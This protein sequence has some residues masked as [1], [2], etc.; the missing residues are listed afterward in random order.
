M[1][2]TE[3]RVKLTGDP[4][5]KLKAFCS[6]TF[7][8]AFVVRDLKIIEGVKG[9]FIAMPSRKLSDRCGRCSNK[10]HLR[11]QYCN[12]CGSELDP[13]RAQRDVRGRA[14]LHADLAHPINS[15]CRITLH[16]SVVAAYHEEVEL[17]KEEGYKSPS[18]DD[19]DEPDEFIDEAYIKDLQQRIPGSDGVEQAQAG[20]GIEQ[21]A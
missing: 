14:R 8:D 9:P 19:F 10:N 2:I 16:K 1:N 21:E 13:D 15:A 6:I 11:A 12:H 4:R 7:D 3:V 17:A 18:F 20:G 5:N